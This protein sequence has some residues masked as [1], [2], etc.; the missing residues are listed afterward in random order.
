[1]MT[2]KFKY[3]LRYL[4]LFVLLVSFISIN[5]PAHASTKLVDK[6]DIQIVNP[7]S[8]QFQ[9]TM[10]V[11][12]TIGVGIAPSIITIGTMATVTVNLN[13]VPI[14]GYTS[15][16]VTCTYYPDL[17]EARDIVVGDL[18]GA[19]PVVAI[20]GPQSDHFVVAIAGS[21]GR[22]A[23]NSGT[24][25]TFH[26]RGLQL[27]LFPI[28]CQARVS[29]GNQTLT[30]LASTSNDLTVLSP[31]STPKTDLCDSAEFIANVN[32]PPGTVMFPGATFTKTWRL[33]NVGTCTWT[34]SY[35]LVFS[36]GEKMGGP[37]F[38]NLSINVAPGQ[39]V[40]LSIHLTAPNTPGSYTGYWMFK[41]ANGA[42]FGIGTSTNEPFSV[43]IIVSNSTVTSTPPTNSPTPSI[44]SFPSIT[45]G[46][47]TATPIGGVAYDF[48]AN[49]CSQGRWFSGVGQLPCPGIDGNP[50]GFVLLLDH[51]VLETGMTDPRHGLLT[52]PQNIQNGYIQGIY[53]P[54]HVQNGDRFRSFINCENGA[55]SCYLAFRLDYQIGIDS[56]K[57][58]W[59]PYLE[60]YDGLGYSTDVDLSPLAG[61]DVKFILT[62][63][64]AG[65]ANGDRAEWVNPIIYRSDLIAT[66]TPTATYAPRSS[67]TPPVSSN[68]I[69]IT[70]PNGGEVLMTGSTYRITWDSTSDINT[71]Y[72]GYKWGD[73]GMDWI[74]P[75]IPNTGYYDWNVLLV[76][77]PASQIKIYI[78]GYGTAQATDESDNF[79]TIVTP[80]TTVAPTFTPIASLTATPLPFGWLRGHVLAGKPVIVSLYDINNNPVVA[81]AFANLDGLFSLYAPVGT[82]RILATS[83]GF[84]SAQSSVT[85]TSNSTTTKPDLTL[86]A[87]DIDGNNAIDQFDALTIGMNYNTPSPAAADLNNDGIINVLD[88]ELLAKHYRMTGPVIWQ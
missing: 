62:I 14:E 88:L 75:G 56:I 81:V 7:K 28:T 29:T 71:V 40:D 57:T 32:I 39:T 60:R 61:K 22:K 87:G 63:L 47:P 11:Q 16:E 15:I 78:Y 30:S 50:N 21:H 48:A 2:R 51:P 6:L 85:I 13:N 67:S 34:T 42:L 35:Q 8:P 9:D 45:P 65:S 83:S 26:V 76:G 84:L 33:T 5:Q 46:G 70:S 79:L 36:N 59:G 23:T 58:L 24:I 69:R 52:F 18:F 27:G 49:A 1:M 73:S 38:S 41:N 20:Q 53:P 44:T 19:D 25:L 72:I 54:F 10:Q 43:N 80:I 37:S 82:Y 12:P 3:M 55:T 77:I 86:V 74:A 64:A 31:T 17:V 68:F 4:S 66:V